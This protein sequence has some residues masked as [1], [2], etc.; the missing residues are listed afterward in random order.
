M[1]NWIK[2]NQ[3]KIAIFIGYT[4]VFLLAFGLGKISTSV[5]RPP[6]IKIED[7]QSQSQGNNTSIIQG[8]QSGV[9]PL[10]SG[11]SASGTADCKGK[12]K[13]NIGASG[14]IYHMPGGAF[15]DR[16]TPEMCFDTEAQAKVAG[17]RKS[18]R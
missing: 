5:Q 3:Q 1:N 2:Q 10:E 13:G 9:Q 11:A 7:Q 16:T 18:Q 4:L 14:K 12:I 6:E 8:L 17:F 15:Y